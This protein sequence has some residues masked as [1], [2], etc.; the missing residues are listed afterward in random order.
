[1]Q[2]FYPPA[3][4]HH[5]YLESQHLLYIEQQQKLEVQVLSHRHHMQAEPE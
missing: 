3:I 2:L 4:Y 1:M 5:V